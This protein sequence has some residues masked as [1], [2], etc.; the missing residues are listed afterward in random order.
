MCTLLPKQAYVLHHDCVSWAHVH[1]LRYFSLIG[2]INLAKQNI[3]TVRGA[4]TDSNSNKA[5][6]LC[7][8]S[9][10]YYYPCLQNHATQEYIPVGCVPPAC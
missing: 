10:Y 4:F 3:K 9:L 2:S 5:H 6:L 7:M 8:I 1:R